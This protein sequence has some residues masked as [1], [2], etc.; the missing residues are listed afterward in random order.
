[1]EPLETD[2]P[3]ESEDQAA[4]PVCDACAARRDGCQACARR[5]ARAE[6]RVERLEI[7]A[8]AATELALRVREQAIQ[9]NW[10][11]MDGPPVFD[12]MVRIVRLNTALA[13]RIEAEER[14]AQRPAAAPA[15]TGAKAPE[16][17]ARS[18][19]EAVRQAVEAAVMADAER[20][21][22]EPRE[23]ED[24]LREMR[25]RASDK[26]IEA[27]LATWPF[28]EIVGAL[29][30]ELGVAPDVIEAE[31]VYVDGDA[32]RGPPPRPPGPGPSR[33]GPGSP[34]PGGGRGPP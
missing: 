16:G 13:M 29:C 11:G 7:L 9:S 25:D 32:G 24:L 21:E 4:S 28:E 33:P 30:K 5:T 27:M 15:T 8:D 22:V 1:M 31:A 34:P 6:R 19:P 23:V 20:R 18:R 3:T 10:L 14:R 17:G 12:K 26:R 2:R